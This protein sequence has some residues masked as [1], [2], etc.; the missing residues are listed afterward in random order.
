MT[1]II[2][3]ELR[4]A[5]T[6]FLLDLAEPNA[7]K[8]YPDQ[9]LKAVGGKEKLILNILWIVRRCGYATVDQVREGRKIAYWEVKVTGKC[10]NVKGALFV[11]EATATKAVK[12][13]KPVKVAS[14]V[15]APKAK[16]VKSEEDIR[17]ANLAKMKKV[18]AQIAKK[19]ATKKKR[20]VD[21][22]EDT[23]GTS[24]EIATSFNIDPSWD[25]VEGLDIQK[26]V[27]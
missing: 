1:C 2:S 8:V 12:T 20:V 14:A 7:G 11:T 24:G 10:P 25:S 18:S 5:R 4:F 27:V 19:A 15:K 3:E 13:A 23:F 26:L 22:V 17:A 6:Q 9:F 16:A 21:Y